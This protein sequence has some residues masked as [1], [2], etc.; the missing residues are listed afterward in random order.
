ML[1]IENTKKNQVGPVELAQT[2]ADARRKARYRNTKL[3]QPFD[4][5]DTPEEEKEKIPEEWVEDYVKDMFDDA[6]GV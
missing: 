2:D 5:A 4:E 6:L 3:R 1:N